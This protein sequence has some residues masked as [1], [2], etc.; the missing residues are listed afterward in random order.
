[1]SSQTTSAPIGVTNNSIN[2]VQHQIAQKNSSTPYY[3]D[4]HIVSNA[5][6]DMD[7]FP[8]PRFFRGIPTDPN[9]NV[10]EREAGFRNLYPD[11]YTPLLKLEASPKPNVCFRPACTTIQPCL[12][13]SER[14]IAQMETNNILNSQIAH[15]NSI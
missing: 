7:V 8:Y 12:G 5:I 2:F 10:F 11:G 9:P 15:N 13:T 6:T 14:N 4:R 3:A 1:M